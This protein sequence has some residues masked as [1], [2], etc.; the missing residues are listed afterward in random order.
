MPQQQAHKLGFTLVELLV[1]IAIIAMLVTLL[2]PAVQA[3]RAAARRT[4]CAN[5]LKQQGIAMHSYA[6]AKSDVFPPGSPGNLLHGLFTYMLPYLEEG[7]IYEQVDLQSTNQ[8]NPNEAQN[9]ARYQVIEPYVCPVLPTPR[10]IP[11]AGG[12]GLSTWST[13]DIPGC[14]WCSSSRAAIC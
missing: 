2:L 12:C 6:S 9:P 11:R 5:N 8:H 14:R 10:R 13:D 3:A 7:A 4:Q 1:V